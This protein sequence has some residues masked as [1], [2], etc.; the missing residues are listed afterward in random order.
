MFRRKQLPYLET[1]KTWKEST[2]K[3]EKKDITNKPHVSVKDKS[4]DSALG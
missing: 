3:N 2:G 1:G 4:K